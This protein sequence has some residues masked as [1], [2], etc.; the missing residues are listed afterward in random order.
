MTIDTGDDKMTID[1][2]EPQVVEVVEVVETVK[3][4]RK[5]YPDKRDMAV[6]FRD[7]RKRFPLKEQENRK[8]ARARRSEY[9]RSAKQYIVNQ[10]GGL[11]GECGYSKHIAALEFHHVDREDKA[12]EICKMIEKEI[13]HGNKTP[14]GIYKAIKDELKKCI[15][16]CSNCHRVIH[17]NGFVKWE[18]WKN[19]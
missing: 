5:K 15:L 13:Y 3:K 12:E 1:T 6:Y 2:L 9:T 7:Y 11:C 8:R 18:E 19:K 14:E 17:A 16:L 10:F 4:P